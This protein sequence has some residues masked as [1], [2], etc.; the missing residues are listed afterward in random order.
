MQI[1]ERH[2]NAK[3]SPCALFL[4]PYGSLAIAYRLLASFISIVD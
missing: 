3:F 1:D 2:K 4:E